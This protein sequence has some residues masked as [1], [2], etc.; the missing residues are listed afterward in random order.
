MRY[1]VAK[2]T[3]FILV[4]T[5]FVGCGDFLWPREVNT[6]YTSH[7]W[8][9]S[10]ICPERIL[11]DP[12]Q[13][14]N[15]DRFIANVTEYTNKVMVELAATG[16]LD[17]DV[18]RPGNKYMAQLEITISD[19]IVVRG[20]YN[21]G[22]AALVLYPESKMISVYGHELVRHLLNVSGD[23]A[24]AMNSSLDWSGDV[25]ILWTI[26]ENVSLDFLD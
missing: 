8:E 4:S 1:T 17:D 7:P 15:V 14:R 2:I 24:L 12:R 19:Q 5:L 25:G 23:R 6:I 3:L 18:T 13:A 21:V 11:E 22:N 26:A 10:V 9:F 20:Y 16:L